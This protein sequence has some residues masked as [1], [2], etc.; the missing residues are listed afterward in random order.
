MGSCSG[1]RPPVCG[2]ASD[3]SFKPSRVAIPLHCEFGHIVKEPFERNVPHESMS[4]C[5]VC[6]HCRTAVGPRPHQRHTL[7]KQIPTAVCRLHF[8]RQAVRQRMLAHLTRE[9]VAR[10]LRARIAEDRPVPSSTTACSL[11]VARVAWH[12]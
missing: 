8:G 11:P 6:A 12:V 5:A 3:N 1:Q 4:H 7:H 2:S 9:R 10:R